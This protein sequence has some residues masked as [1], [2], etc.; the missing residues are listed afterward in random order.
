[1]S[2]DTQSKPYGL[3]DIKVKSLITGVVVDLPAAVT[4]SF[5]ERVKAAEGPGDDKLSTVVAVIDAVEWELENTGLPL[6]AY[7]IMHG[8]EPTEAGTTPNQTKTMTGRGAVR[9]PYFQIFGKSLGEGEDDV[10]IVIYKAKVTEGIDAKFAYGELFKPTIK[11][12]GIDDEINGIWDFVQ[13]ETATDLD[14]GS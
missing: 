2:L 10:H 12:I 3:N 4:L 13:E 11:G 8:T 5:K 7:A 1:M 14:E 9:L 6:D